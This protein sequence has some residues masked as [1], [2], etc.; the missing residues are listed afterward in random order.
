MEC[1][2]KVGLPFHAAFFE[3]PPQGN[4]FDLDATAHQIK[5]VFLGNLR[6]LEAFIL[7]QLDEAFGLKPHQ[8]FPDRAVSHA[9]ALAQSFHAQ[10]LVRH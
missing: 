6:D 8:G 3:R 2:E 10:P 9:I 1:A 4:C 7:F 5:K